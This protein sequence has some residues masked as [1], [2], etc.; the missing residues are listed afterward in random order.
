LI[1]SKLKSV[2]EHSGNQFAEQSAGTLNARV[3]VDF[4]QPHL[5]IVADKVVKSKQF[6]TVFSLVKVYFLFY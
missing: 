1:D 3:F 4:N 2:I 5:L 6:E